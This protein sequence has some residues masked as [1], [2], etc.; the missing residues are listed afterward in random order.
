MN[1]LF[2]KIPVYQVFLSR[3]SLEIGQSVGKNYE[4]FVLR[5][6]KA[7]P[8]IRLDRKINLLSSNNL[9]R[10]LINLDHFET[11]SRLEDKSL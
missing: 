10:N 11:K 5:K 1:D 7:K 3:T 2:H 9:K 8:N 4:K 6:N